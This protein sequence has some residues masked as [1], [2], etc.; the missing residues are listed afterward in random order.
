MARLC[1]AYYGIYN[2]WNVRDR[3]RRALALRTL[4]VIAM[5]FLSVKLIHHDTD[6][7]VYVVSFNS[8]ALLEVFAYRL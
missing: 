6:I 5:P 1:N 3:R 2:P 7:C 4:R 8:P